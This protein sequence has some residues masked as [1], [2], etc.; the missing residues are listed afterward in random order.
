M[1]R[2]VRLSGSNT[3]YHHGHRYDDQL[4]RYHLQSPDRH[5]N[6]LQVLPKIHGAG[7]IPNNDLFNPAIARKSNAGVASRILHQRQLRESN[8]LK[9]FSDSL[10]S[11]N[12]LTTQDYE[13]TDTSTPPTFVAF[14][15]SHSA[16]QNSY[17]SKQ[18]PLNESFHPEV[19]K[20]PTSSNQYKSKHAAAKKMLNLVKGKRIVNDHHKQI[21]LG[22]SCE[23][24]KS[25]LISQ[26]LSPNTSGQDNRHVM[27]VMKR[28]TSLSSLHDLNQR[29]PRSHQQ[30][31]QNVDTV[32]YPGQNSKMISETKFCRTKQAVCQLIPDLP[33]RNSQ[34]AAASL[35]P[36]SNK[37]T[38]RNSIDL[39]YAFPQL[40]R[41]HLHQDHCDRRRYTRVVAPVHQPVSSPAMKS[42][43]EP[44]AKPS[45][46]IN[47]V[48]NSR[49]KQSNPKPTRNNRYQS[50]VS[51]QSRHLSSQLPRTESFHELIQ[52]RATENGQRMRTT[53]TLR[54]AANGTEAAATKVNLVAE[55][56]ESKR[57]SRQREIEAKKD[58]VSKTSDSPINSPLTDQ[59]C[60]DVSNSGVATQGEVKEDP[61]KK[62]SS[63]QCSRL[64]AFSQESDDELVDGHEPK[65][66]ET[67][68]IHSTAYNSEMLQKSTLKR[69]LSHSALQAGQSENK[70]SIYELDGDESDDLDELARF[71][72]QFR[73]RQSKLTSSNDQQVSETANL[74]CKQNDSKA[75]PKR[76][77]AEESKACKYKA[78]DVS[79]PSEH[80]HNN[81][82]QNLQQSPNST[83]S[84][85]GFASS[86]GTSHSI[87]STS[88]AP[89]ESAIDINR[90]HKQPLAGKC[91]AP[92]VPNG[93]IC[94]KDLKLRQTTSLLSIADEYRHQSM[95]QNSNN[96]T[97]ISGSSPTDSDIGSNQSES[98]R[99]ESRDPF[100]LATPGTRVGI[101]NDRGSGSRAHL[102]TDDGR[103]FEG[104]GK[105]DPAVKNHKEQLNILEKYTKLRQMSQ[106]ELAINHLN[107]STILELP[108]YP[109]GAGSKFLKLGK[110]GIVN[111]ETDCKP[112]RSRLFN[113]I[114]RI[115]DKSDTS[116]DKLSGS[117]RTGCSA[118]FFEKKQSFSQVGAVGGQQ[119][120]K[121]GQPF[122]D[123]EKLDA[124]DQIETNASPISSARLVRKKE[125][126]DQAVAVDS[127]SDVLDSRNERNFAK[128]EKG[129]AGRAL[130]S[131]ET[132][133][134]LELTSSKS[135]SLCDLNF[136]C[137]LE[138]IKNC[139]STNDY[140]HEEVIRRAQSK[141]AAFKKSIA[142]LPPVV[143]R[144]IALEQDGLK[145][146]ASDNNEQKHLASGQKKSRQQMMHHQRVVELSNKQN[147]WRLAPLS[148]ILEKSCNNTKKHPELPC[149]G[150]CGN[151]RKENNRDSNNNKRL[152][153]V[154]QAG[155]ERNSPTAQVLS[156]QRNKSLLKW[157][158]SSWLMKA[159]NSQN[160]CD[161]EVQEQSGHGSTAM[162]SPTG[163]H[164]GSKNYFIKLIS[165]NGGS[166]LKKTKS[167]LSSCDTRSASC[168]SRNDTNSIPH[169]QF[170]I[171]NE[172]DQLLDELNQSLDLVSNDGTFREDRLWWT[173][174]GKLPKDPLKLNNLD[175]AKFTQD[176]DTSFTNSDTEC[177]LNSDYANISQAMINET[178]GID[179]SLS[180]KFEYKPVSRSNSFIF[181]APNTEITGPSKSDV[182]KPVNGLNDNLVRNYSNLCST[183]LSGQNNDSKA[184]SLAS[185]MTKPNK[186]CHANT[187]NG[188]N[189]E[190]SGILRISVRN[191]ALEDKI[192]IPH[193]SNE[194]SKG[195]ELE[196]K[197]SRNP[198]AA[199]MRAHVDNSHDDAWGVERAAK[200][201]TEVECNSADGQGVPR[202]L[203]RDISRCRD[204]NDENDQFPK[205]RDIKDRSEVGNKLGCKNH[206]NRPAPVSH[207][208]FTKKARQLADVDHD[209]IRVIENSSSDCCT[210]LKVE[211][212][213]SMIEAV[214]L[215]NSELD[216]GQNCSSITRNKDSHVACLGRQNSEF[217]EP[218]AQ[219]T[220]SCYDIVEDKKQSR[221]RNHSCL[222][223]SRHITFE[224]RC[225]SH[226]ET[227]F[228]TCDEQDK[229]SSMEHN[230]LCSDHER[231][232]PAHRLANEK[233]LSGLPT[234]QKCQISETERATQNAASLLKC[235]HQC[236]CK[237]VNRVQNAHRQFGKVDRATETRIENSNGEK[238]ESLDIYQKERARHLYL[239]S[240]EGQSTFYACTATGALGKCHKINCPDGDNCSGSLEQR[241]P[242]V[243]G[244]R[245]ATTRESSSESVSSYCCRCQISGMDFPEVT[246]RGRLNKDCECSTI[247]EDDKE[248]NYGQ[249]EDVCVGRKRSSDCM[250]HATDLTPGNRRDK[251][252]GLEHRDSNEGK[253]SYGCGKAHTCADSKALN[254]C[255]PKAVKKSINIRKPALQRYCPPATNEP[256]VLKS[257]RSSGKTSE[258]SQSAKVETNGDTTAEDNPRDEADEKLRGKKDACNIAHYH[259]SQEML[260]TTDRTNDQ[261][262]RVSA[263]K[264]KTKIHRDINGSHPIVTGNKGEQ[265]RTACPQQECKR[266]T[267]K[268]ATRPKTDLSD[269]NDLRK[270][271]RTDGVG[272]TPTC[273]C[274][275]FCDSA[276]NEPSAETCEVTIGSNANRHIKEN[277]KVEK[278]LLPKRW[279]CHTR[280]E[281]VSRKM[282]EY[283]SSNVPLKDPAAMDRTT[284]DERQ[285]PNLMKD[286]LS[287]NHRLDM[288]LNQFMPRIVD[289][290]AENFILRRKT[291]NA[292]LK[293][294]F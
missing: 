179:L 154:D 245:K 145:I 100:E 177:D 34:L 160:L 285:V 38:R 262:Q 56:L 214:G 42:F 201:N 123:G 63:P 219:T 18:F 12:N 237:H 271:C 116:I 292:G 96:L 119:T 93:V 15:S 146:I 44:E 175:A 36:S 126:D 26:N 196:T 205:S 192:E 142:I 78:N 35:F 121:W 185:S 72:Y 159:G 101:T 110:N 138:L 99:L 73:K 193:S 191:A 275:V 23:P 208:T 212:E 135:G 289:E 203:S 84:S 55:L 167:T 37:S 161:T 129:A 47:L 67:D 29:R 81:H 218:D 87:S 168:G 83:T 125:F 181:D 230:H 150:V 24:I 273:P 79:T 144:K 89:H 139:G 221:C 240:F 162:N 269:C 155:A 211:T 54:G 187:R 223:H 164:S 283:K 85:S 141:Q 184:E 149:D 22:T 137:D 64:Q 13:L 11:L 45:S 202:K 97:T 220:T 222:E 102:R 70:S 148:S 112:Y 46:K 186:D 5:F 82:G 216:N 98:L 252:P 170:T 276:G 215:N 8:A 265:A 171:E 165:G 48:K 243:E 241:Q 9:R 294:Q 69:S 254:N 61:L 287:F 248:N 280:D 90:S 178:F 284:R 227:S 122:D 172:A 14:Q 80:K 106:S 86:T 278:I 143:S 108:D 27:V 39:D 259:Y 274:S 152:L 200:D 131:T 120:R 239:R 109:S 147:N 250:S 244:F 231:R 279:P 180:G 225:S 277:D 257:S 53:G 51:Q 115:S 206:G 50:K 260:A 233:K 41:S 267:P 133:R 156:K 21:D 4:P 76:L 182:E 286:P 163:N 238:P 95:K 43:V 158:A 176:S 113:L 256:Q 290:Y 166:G 127:L 204:T 59:R 258:L 1:N 32:D 111:D 28:A 173:D 118:R 117:K 272:L 66:R 157:P 261:R 105:R 94:T 30:H 17:N 20:S 74:I 88:A 288:G 132:N 104:L 10:P 130:Q 234:H 153:S 188:K 213:G 31:Q 136:D 229:V 228:F 291:P 199:N 183:E 124:I 134:R 58:D 190:N 107:T 210:A 226:T 209:H 253:H 62:K 251:I 293:T 7:R 103:N 65:I 189:E 19:T 207:S 264:D 224:K 282:Q 249:P 194:V 40:E 2:D 3:E 60:T 255:E 140:K 174:E 236:Q 71:L 266:I 151:A 247:L 6:P 217:R 235:D 128:G 114:R 281:L 169:P 263:L 246:S 268:C 91:L 49:Y 25:K 33:L 16:E 68:G 92:Q 52:L 232:G 77:P 270:I 195:S 57:N 75:S 197:A 198:T 242:I